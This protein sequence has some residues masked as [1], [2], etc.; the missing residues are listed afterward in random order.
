MP[1]LIKYLKKNL[2]HFVLQGVC[3]HFAGAE[4]ITNYYRIKKQIS[5]YRKFIRLFNRSGLPPKIRHTASSA[6][7]LT[8]PGTVMDMVRIGIAQY[9]FWPSPE[10]QMYHFKK[11]PKE[12]YT[13]KRLLTW[14]TAIMAI[15]HVEAGSF[16]G[17]GTSYLSNKKIKIA[18]VP[19]GYANGFSRALSNTGRVLIGGRR[20]PVIGMVTMNTMTVNVTDIPN[21][22]KGDEVVIFGKQK[23]LTISIAS[24]G[25]MSNDMNYQLI[26][27]LPANIP[28]VMV[29]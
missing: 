3:T 21:V 20:V 14:K 23:R 2:E 12:V 9:G 6:A 28:R 25:E 26:T 27:R 13:L 7:A 5:E 4:S 22:K 19:V 1:E 10:T 17:Y 11:N 16:V 15:K 18:I 24:F 8:Y 29:K